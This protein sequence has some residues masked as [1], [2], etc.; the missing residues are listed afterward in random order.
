MHAVGALNNGEK[1]DY[2][3][4][5]SIGEY[6][7]LRRVS[8]GGAWAG[9]RAELA[10]FPDQKFSVACLCNLGSTNPSALAMKVADLYL[11]GPI[12]AL[13]LKKAE[14]I[15]AK[16]GGEAPGAVVITEANLKDKA[17]VYRKIGRSVV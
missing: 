6:K 16:T 12:K 4:G 8:H 1:H 10:R 3:A 5:L 14:E 11:A 17:G 15:N 13:E 9:Y 2:A 7:G